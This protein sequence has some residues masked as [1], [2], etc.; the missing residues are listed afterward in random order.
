M[1]AGVTHCRTRPR[2]HG[3]KSMGGRTGSSP[4][5]V[6]LVTPSPVFGGPHNQALLLARWLEPHGVDLTVVLPT[7]PGSAVE[8]LADAGVDVIQ[9]E[10]HR[11]RASPHPIAQL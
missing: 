1:R 8:R 11:L 6:L 10:L 2:A 5:R 7:E 3:G 4:M 9:T